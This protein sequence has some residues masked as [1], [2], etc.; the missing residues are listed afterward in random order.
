MFQTT[1]QC[2]NNGLE[3]ITTD[4]QR[5]ANSDIYIYIVMDNKDFNDG[6]IVMYI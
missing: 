6:I 2:Y 5:W 1:N 4:S 3:W